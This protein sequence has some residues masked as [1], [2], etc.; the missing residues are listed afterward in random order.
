MC[1]F[2]ILLAR[3]PARQS[4][5]VNSRWGGIAW[6]GIPYAGAVDGAHRWTAPQPPQAWGPAPFDATQ[7]PVGCLSSHHNP[8]VANVTTENCLNL[9]VYVPD[10]ATDDAALPVLFWIHGGGFA[11]GANTGPYDLYQGNHM[12]AT[13]KVIVVA[14][15]YRL[16]AFGFLA[17]SSGTETLRG[18]FGLMDQQLGECLF[19][20]VCAFALPRGFYALLRVLAVRLHFFSL[21]PQRCVG[22][23]GMR[24]R[25]AATRRTWCSGASRPA[26]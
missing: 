16:G 23:R 14:V 5:Q 12:A 18:N 1:H 4:G 24:A 22:C 17:L 20:C 2:P 8:D 9:N 19:S 25:L 7:W 21:P 10:G 6:L 11:E 26:Q 3:L 15:N 13:A